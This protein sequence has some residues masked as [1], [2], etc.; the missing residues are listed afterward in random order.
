MDPV[1]IPE[2]NE[3]LCRGAGG[4]I[5]AGPDVDLEDIAGDG[6]P[7]RQQVDV[8][9]G[10]LL[11]GRGVG[12]AGL[13]RLDGE[14]PL[15]EV[16]R[17]DGPGVLDLLGKRELHPEVLEVGLGL[18]HPRLAHRQVRAPRP[19]VDREQG[20]PGPDTLAHPDVHPGDD[21]RDVGADGNVAGARLH[22]AGAG[23]PVHE[24]HPRGVGHRLGVDDGPRAL[25]DH[26]QRED[27]ADDRQ[28]GNHVF[29][30]HTAS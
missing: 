28:N 24:G 17:A 8:H 16:L 12:E 3:R 15:V 26:P 21:A 14:A 18:P 7:H 19:V 20:G 10:G 27:D 25:P 1:E 23:D 5:L 9:P 30:D 2:Q 6:R 11:L 13:G 22:D 4:G 29:S